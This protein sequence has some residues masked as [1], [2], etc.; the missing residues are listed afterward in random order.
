MEADDR[1][2]FSLQ[3]LLW[4]LTITAYRAGLFAMFASITVD[5]DG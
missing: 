2:S 1:S 5:L 3:G 4:R